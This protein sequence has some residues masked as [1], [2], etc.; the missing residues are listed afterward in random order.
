MQ[1]S[2]SVRSSPTDDDPMINDPGKHGVNAQGLSVS[3]RASY[4]VFCAVRPAVSA[5]P[6]DEGKK[7]KALAEQIGDIDGVEIYGRVVGV[8]GLM[9]EISGPI[10]AM[11]VG[12]RLTLESGNGPGIPC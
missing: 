8:R 11:T 10:Y 1:P 2:E 5:C 6:N 7:L 3:L 9:V 12:S 4:G